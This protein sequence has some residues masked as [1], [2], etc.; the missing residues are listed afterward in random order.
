MPVKALYQIAYAD[1]NSIMPDNRT[2]LRLKDSTRYTGLPNYLPN[3]DKLYTYDLILPGMDTALLYHCMKEDLARFFGLKVWTEKRKMKAYVFT[4][5]DTQLLRS[6]GGEY[7]ENIHDFE[8]FI[9]NAPVIALMRKFNNFG[10]CFRSPYPL[11][12]QTGISGKIDIILD[13][14][15]N[16][17]VKLDQALYEKYKMHLRLQEAEVNILVISDPV[18]EKHSSGN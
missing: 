2:E 15:M 17:P 6:K 18:S 3:K 7:A 9:Q 13:A 8:V 5:E 12:D 16:D 1:D 14:D 4:A 11:I 10:F